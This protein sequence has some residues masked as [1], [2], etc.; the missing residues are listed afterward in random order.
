MPKGTKP[1][2]ERK[3]IYIATTITSVIGYLSLAKLDRNP[4]GLPVV[5]SDKLLHMGAYTV[6]SFA[7]FLT[8]HKN[9]W[10]R[11]YFSVAFVLLVLY[12]ALL[13]YLQMK[14][15]IHRVGDLLDIAANTMGVL[16]AAAVFKWIYLSNTRDI[17]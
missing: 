3:F 8:G 9:G 7:W 12:G 13:E 5:I 2:S 17:F 6:L 16:L 11:R 1:L 4:L 15:T 10:K 14:L